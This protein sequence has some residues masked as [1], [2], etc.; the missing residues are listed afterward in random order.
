[1]SLGR[2]R[3]RGQASEGFANLEHGLA[4]PAGGDLERAG[5][6]VAKGPGAADP[7]PH[8]AAA[9][10]HLGGQRGGLRRQQ[11]VGVPAVDVE[12]RTGGGVDEM[13]ASAG[14]EGHPRLQPRYGDLEA[15][16]G[17]AAAREPVEVGNGQQEKQA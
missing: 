8:A 15:A 6:A 10:Q 7:E 11:P 12:R 5:P 14:H 16:G 3:R 4:E 13:G 17:A 9:A 2:R 1:M